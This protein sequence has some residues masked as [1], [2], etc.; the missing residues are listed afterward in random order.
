[1]RRRELAIDASRASGVARTGTEWYSYELIRALTALRERP[2]L[3]L[4]HRPP[5][6]PF[7]DAPDVRDRVV[8]APRL[9]THVGLS[10]ALLRDRPCGLFVPSHV[11]PLLHP[12]R[13][14]VTVH[15]LGY[16]HTPA[17][18]GRTARLQLD[19]TTRWNAR[20]AR[21]VIAISSQTRA[22]LVRHY[23]VPPEKVRVVLSAV[24]HER[25]RPFDAREP[26]QALGID[27]PYLLFLST[28]Q[29]R[30]NLVRLVEAFES[31]D[32]PEL[33]LV[34][35]GRTGWLAEPIERRLRESPARER[36][37]RLGH[38]ADA[39]V[40]AL[41]NAAEVFILPSLQE[42]FGMG[43]LEAMACGCP[44]VASDLPSLREVAGDAAIFV[45]PY[46]TQAIRDGILRA[47]HERDR[48]AVAGIARAAAFSWE[49]TARETLAVID[50]ALGE[51]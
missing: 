46:D 9:W 26:V 37:V 5:G 40:P 29:P 49:R 16:L 7:V 11:I 51:R 39:V 36:I 25:F 2:P 42:G 47:L 35:A 22:D 15:D 10:L 17:A 44:V 20:V 28:V 50:E 30:K 4:Y 8:R 41:Y 34:V 27:G 48:L 32:Q 23:R 45:D 12:R 21:R 3:A 18:H 13:S 31:L 33:R 19:L 6:Q 14:V 24:S 38:V 1:M 43:V